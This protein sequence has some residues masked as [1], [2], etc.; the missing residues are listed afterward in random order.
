MS[1][2][3]AQSAGGKASAIIQRKMALERYYLN[4]II[5]KQCKKIILVSEGTRICTIRK[6]KFCNSSCS[7]SY[8]R[9]NKPKKFCPICGTETKNKIYCS[10]KCRGFDRLGIFFIPNLTKGQ[11]FS[12][13]SSWQSARSSI[14][15]NAFQV[16]KRSEKPLIC[17]C[18]YNKHVNICHKKDVSDFPDSATIAEIN[19]ISNLEALCPNHHW[20]LDN[21]LLHI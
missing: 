13:R 15:R 5:C 2:F 19:D 14:R 7:A 16:F 9:L 17:F 1:S 21:G 3:K 20:E 10:K 18:G 4:P 8:K 11:L 6:K 12:K